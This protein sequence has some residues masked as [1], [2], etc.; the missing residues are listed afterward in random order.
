MIE[1]LVA[2]DRAGD[3]RGGEQSGNRHDENRRDAT[4]SI[5][6]QEHRHPE[7]Q[8]PWICRGKQLVFAGQALTVSPPDRVGAPSPAR[9]AFIRHR[10]APTSN[11]AH[12]NRMMNFH[13]VMIAASA[14]PGMERQNSATN[15]KAENFN[16]STRRSAG[17]MRAGAGVSSQGNLP[18]SA[19]R[20]FL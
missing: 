11:A 8:A 1:Q 2:D 13:G 16:K 17:E 5:G 19:A 10:K 20:S 15:T 3:Q 7:H 6:D 9:G 18:S 12:P 4:A 14:Q